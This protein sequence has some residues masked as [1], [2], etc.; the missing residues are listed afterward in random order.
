MC[1]R[2]AERA[3]Q[4][5]RDLLDHRSLRP[6]CGLLKHI[7]R[8]DS[9]PTWWSAGRPPLIGRLPRDPTEDHPGQQQDDE[10]GTDDQQGDEPEVRAVLVPVVGEQQ[11]FHHRSTSE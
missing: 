1:L 6:T 5:S 11:D 2:S 10:H 3:A 7:L 8:P 9:S 4:G